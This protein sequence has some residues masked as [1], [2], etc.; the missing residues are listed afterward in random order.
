MFIFEYKILKF[1][2]NSLLLSSSSSPVKTSSSQTADQVTCDL[3]SSY[4]VQHQP[5]YLEYMVLINNPK[6]GHKQFY[7]AN[8]LKTETTFLC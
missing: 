6:F 4:S 5:Y 8:F 1:E 7:I 2:L 3:E